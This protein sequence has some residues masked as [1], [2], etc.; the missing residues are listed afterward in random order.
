MIFRDVMMYIPNSPRY[1]DDFKWGVSNYEIATKNN[2]DLLIFNRQHLRD[3]TQ[4]GQ[5]DFAAHSDFASTGQFD[6]DDLNGP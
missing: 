5:I 1:E 2:P 6:N 3:Y 4:A